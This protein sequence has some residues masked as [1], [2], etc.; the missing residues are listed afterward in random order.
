[1]SEIEWAPPR[2]PGRS[3]WALI[4]GFIFVVVLSLCTDQV[5]HSAGVYPPWGEPMWD[6]QLNALALSYRLVYDTAGSYITA[7][8]APRAP[9]MHAMIGGVIGFIVTT[10]GAAAMWNAGPHWYPFALAISTLPTAWLGGW[11]YTRRRR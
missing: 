6:P 2:H 4:A 8:L 11:L 10:L 9:M 5:L 3:A 7:R 1:M